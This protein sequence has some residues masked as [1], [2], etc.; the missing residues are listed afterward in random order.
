MLSVLNK[1]T[2]EEIM[3]SLLRRMYIKRHILQG[4]HS[5]S[6]EEESVFILSLQMYTL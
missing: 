2:A 3:T 5:D 4:F 6:S 1:N